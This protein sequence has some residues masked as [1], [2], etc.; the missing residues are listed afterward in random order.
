VGLDL[1]VRVARGEDLPVAGH[2]LDDGDRL[3]LG[4]VVPERDLPLDLVEVRGE[5]LEVLLGALADQIERVAELDLH[6]LVLGRGVDPV[7]ADELL[8]ARA[9]GLV[10]AHLAFRQ[11]YAQPVL[12]AVL[13]LEID[14]DLLIGDRHAVGVAV[15]VRRAVVDELLRDG[16]L[17]RRQQREVLGLV[18]LDRRAAVERVEVVLEQ[19]LRRK[20]VTGGGRRHRLRRRLQHPP[21]A[22]SVRR[23]VHVASHQLERGVA[24][25]GAAFVVDRHPAVQIRERV[26]G[27]EDHDVVGLPGD[28]ARE[29]RRLDALGPRGLVTQEPHEGGLG[30]EILRERGQDETAVVAHVDLTVDLEDRSVGREQSGVVIRAVTLIEP[31]L[32]ADVLLHELLARQEIVLVVLLE[33]LEPGRVGDRLEMDGRRVDQCGDVHELHLRLPRREPHFAEVLHEAEVAVVDGHHDV[34]LLVARHADRRRGG[35]LSGGKRDDQ[36]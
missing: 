2:G 8:A 29:I 13:H 10:D 36:Q 11:R 20:V 22:P 17:A 4:L 14:R 7:L 24:V 30:H 1:L 3:R 6:A 34:A 19:A 12:L 35:R 21:I 27:V 5:L 23:A 16:H 32:A 31:H 15:V 25:G 28:P 9:V 26:G 18:V 33:D